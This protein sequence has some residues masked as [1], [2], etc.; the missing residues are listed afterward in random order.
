MEEK[1]AY[2]KQY[3]QEH[4][5][6]IREYT[7]KYKLKNREH[8]LAVQRELN[9][10]NYSKKIKEP[11]LK[12]KSEPKQEQEPILEI[13]IQES[14]KIKIERGSFYVLLHKN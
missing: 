4:K 14:S 7:R 5:E 10:K 13:P 8:V 12:P 11:K 9:H 6:Q 2:A 1:K 3:R